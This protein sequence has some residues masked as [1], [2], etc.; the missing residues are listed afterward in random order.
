LFLQP[1]LKLLLNEMKDLPL[2]MR[3]VQTLNL[4]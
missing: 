4:I 3:L 1:M 2:K